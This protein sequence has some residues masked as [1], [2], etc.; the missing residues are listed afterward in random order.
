MFT[1]EQYLE[2]LCGR[3]KNVDFD[4]V[5]SDLAGLDFLQQADLGIIDKGYLE[6]LDLQDLQDVQEAK[7]SRTSARA[8]SPS[9]TA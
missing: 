4:R 1:D 6:G 9:M 8:L 5:M 7:V 3:E 2:Y